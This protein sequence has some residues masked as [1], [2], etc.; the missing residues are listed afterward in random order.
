M[1]GLETGYAVL[2]RAAAFLA[3]PGLP[4]TELTGGLQLLRE[5]DGI[6]V[7]SSAVR[8]PSDRW[9]QMPPQMDSVPIALP[10]Q[11][12]LAGGWKF[13]AER[14]RLPALAWEQA[15]QNADRYQVWLDGGEL[16]EGLELRV[17]RKGDVFRPAGLRGHSQKVS[18]F[19]I[20]ARL[21]KR[22]RDRWPLLCAGDQIIWVPGY[23][24]AQAFKLQQ[25]SGRVVYFALARPPERLPE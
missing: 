25:A 20:N 14:W 15:S 5:G 18:D 13:S 10:G 8:L 19:F 21:P 24:L 23:R 2:T 4:R 6:Y 16:P 9:P 12:E 7:A 11:I 22:A 1:P 17:R 3:D